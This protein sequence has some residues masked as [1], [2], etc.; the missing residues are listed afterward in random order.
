MLFI[1]QIGYYFIYLFQQYQIKEA[2]KEQ[3]L[4][5]IPDE[6]LIAINAGLNKDAIEWE[7][8]G[9]EFSMNGD[10]YDVARIKTVN[11]N[12]ILYC[13]NDTKEDQLLEEL[14]KS[15]RS[16]NDN[17]ATGKDAKHTIKFQMVDFVVPVPEK[18]TTISNLLA[19]QKFA[20]YD[21]AILSSIKEIDLPP[22]KINHYAKILFYEKS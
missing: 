18:I 16:A 6:S 4:K 5:H 11:G 12:T 19:Q 2:V 3:L 10:M 13:I 14:A 20:E 17:T 8:E 9:R 1:S 7:E 22:P 15:V 21:V